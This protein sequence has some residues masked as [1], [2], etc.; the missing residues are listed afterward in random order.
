MD[1]IRLLAEGCDNMQGFIFTHS[2]GGGT[3]SGFA[4]RVLSTLGLDYG[5][6]NRLNV[7][8]V[9]SS[10]YSTCSTEPYNAV[11][12]LYNIIELSDLAMIVDNTAIARICQQ[13]LHIRWP[14]LAD[15]NVVIAQALS[16]VTYSMRCPSLMNTSLEEIKSSLVPYP[17]LSFLSC[18]MSPYVATRRAYE[19][20]TTV[21]DMTRA[22]FSGQNSLCEL[23]PKSGKYLASSLM[24]YGDLKAQEVQSA[25]DDIRASNT[26]QFVEGVNA[27]IR[28]GIV[29]YQP[30]TTPNGNLAKVSRSVTMLANNTAIKSVFKRLTSQ[31]RTLLNKNAY[32][33]H[34]HW[35]GLPHDEIEGALADMEN[36]VKDYDE[37]ESYTGPEEDENTTD[38]SM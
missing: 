30:S 18:A 6:K 29:P 15:L 14:T 13:Q 21:N 31:A 3:G 22:V 12:A 1:R 19:K 5:K 7:A 23:D 28:C 2:I 11:L 26:V 16:N 32:Y 24:Y 33:Y 8:V 36:L 34:L 35:E 10:T 17:R 20:S 38:D 37:M 25:L 9:P 4:A 27:S